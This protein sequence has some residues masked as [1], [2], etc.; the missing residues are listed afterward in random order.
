M[1][2]VAPPPVPAVRAEKRVRRRW[3]II[4]AA[5]CLC[6]AAGWLVCRSGRVH[7]RVRTEIFRV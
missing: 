5:A 4:A 3:G 7:A 6:M 2:A 1:S